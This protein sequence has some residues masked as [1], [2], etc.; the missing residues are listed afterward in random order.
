MPDLLPDYVNAFPD[1]TKDWDVVYDARGVLIEPHTG[2]EVPLGTIEV[3]DYLGDRA[4]LNRR[5]VEIADALLY[6]TRGPENRF[7][8]VLFVEKEA[9]WPLLRKAKI[10]ERYDIALTSTKGLSNTAARHVFDRMTP[11]LKSILVLHDFD[12]AGFTIFGTLAKNSRRYQFENS[13]PVIDI[14]L[15]LTDIE[16]MDLDFE[17]CHVAGFDSRIE[18]LRAYGA[19]GFEI[20]K[21]R[22]ER[23]ELNAMPSDVFIEFLETK[24]EACGVEKIVPSPDILNAQAH[25][26]IEHR[27]AK[28]RLAAMQ[29]EI[30]AEAVADAQAVLSV[31]FEGVVRATLKQRPE[32]SWEEAIAMVVG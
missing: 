24:L 19:T 10:A 15:R 25:R 22:D 21:L 20:R 3:R 6:P 4:P 31:D 11:L 17:P 23:V 26:V 30:A 32:L 1:E 14:G 5:A 16:A 29:A 13:V 18:T 8:A 9:F 27:I 28:A 12:V 7:Q 2:L